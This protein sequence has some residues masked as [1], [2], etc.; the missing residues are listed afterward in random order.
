MRKII[1]IL[2]ALTL[3]TCAPT[4]Y[5]DYRDYPDESVS[6]EMKFYDDPLLDS[7]YRA[8]YLDCLKNCA[9]KNCD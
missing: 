1:F 6:Q 7:V 4:Q 3:F 9:E 5:Y 2:M 8:R